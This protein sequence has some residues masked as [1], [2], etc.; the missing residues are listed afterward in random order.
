MM[1]EALRTILPYAGWSEDRAKDVD[2]TGPTDPV[3]PTTFKITETGVAALAA[4]G[5][6]AADLWELRSGRRQKID[7][8]SRHATASL[9]SGHY[10]VMEGSKVDWG[11]NPVAGVYPAK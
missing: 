5:L 8:D 6:A 2:V 10:L 4:V 7:I 3:L 11:R 9:R 1:N